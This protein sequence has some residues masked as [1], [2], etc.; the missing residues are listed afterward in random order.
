M[1]NVLQDDCIVIEKYPFGNSLDHLRDALRK[2]EESYD[3]VDDGSSQGAQE[4]VS[5]LLLALMG[6]KS[7]Y[8]L[9]SQF[10]NQNVAYEIS[11]LFR[12]I[13]N[14]DFHYERY[15][16]LVRLVIHKASDAEIWSAVF[17]L[18]TTISRLTP[19]T[20]IAPSFDGTPIT[21]SSASQQGSEQTE[22]LSKA[23]IF[24]EIMKC[25]Y[26]GVGGF[27]SKY[28]EGKVWTQRSKEIYNTMKSR[29]VDGQWIDFP[30]PPVQNAVSE[31]LFRFQDEFLSDARG[32]YYTTKK[33][34]EFTGAEAPRQLD[35]FVKR[36]SETAST[37]HD[38]KDVYIIGEHKQT[39]DHLKPL[40]LQLSRYMR[41][42]FTAQPRR[43]FIHGF[44]LH[45]TTMEPW[46]FDRSGP[47]S[48]GEFDIHEEPE[49]FI[50][51]IT[52]Y[53]MMSDEELGLDTFV[54]R[55]RG[56]LFITIT[57][58]ATGK[59]KRLQLE[60][61][62]IAIQRAI[63]CRGTSCYRTED[64]EN[65]A[66]FSWTS[67]KRPSEADLLRLALQKG[68]E[69]VARL[70]G[71]HRITSIEEMREK[72]TFPT[73]HHFRNTSP[74]ASESFSESFSQSQSLQP[75]SQS[76]GSFRRL[77]IVKTSSNKRKS[78]DSEAKCSKRS[79]S[80][81][82]RSKLH[83]E[84]KVTEALEST[85]TTERKAADN[86]AKL[87]KK[88]TST[89][90][91]SKPLQE[92]NVPQ[93]PKSAHTRKR[94]S[95]D[96]GEKPSKR[97]RSDSQRSNVQQ[98]Y[99]VLQAFKDT[100]DESFDNRVFGC[101]VIWPAGRAIKDFHSIPELLTALRDAIKAHKSLYLRATILHRDI[102]ENNMI[103]TNPKQT[104]GFTGMLIDADL[105]KIIGGGRTGA[106]YQT[107]TMEF[108]A[109]QVLRKVDHTYRHD[110]ESFFY[111]LL[112]I[113]ARRAW[114]REF[115][116]KW[117]DRPKESMLRKWYTGSYKEIAQS[118]EYAMGVNGFEELLEEFPLILECI[119]PLCR[120]IR[121]ILFPY[122]NG[123]F[124]GTPLDPKELYDPI[125]KAFDDAI[126]KERARER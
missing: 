98:G 29:H 94:K 96:N 47:Y 73:P 118:K 110:L 68:V 62:P 35:L 55:N 46:V 51:A 104:K 39:K 123:M 122:Q 101:L 70:L 24:H 43:R 33:T 57:E 120:E 7:A 100:H 71:Y 88:S 27:F 119:M 45:G 85:Q 93:A 3:A 69:G 40:L 109:I 75:L 79:R 10:S 74:N 53:A 59:E 12:R 31:W 112:W 111:V 54:E 30:D 66:K 8:I 80:N 44:F 21:H 25:T 113:C 67:H 106:R 84:H 58:D 87:F 90:Q 114:E 117:A 56:D 50:Q 14:H 18:I 102:S 103:I 108:M 16:A 49:Q 89:S 4:A 99:E 121:G 2:V 64:S 36:R 48:S 60:R 72:L 17:N 19:P 11:T 63:V 37:T 52:G 42:V 34:S 82:Q 76:F 116:C 61:D 92:H 81:S 41:D 20:S 38:W 125:I 13:Q 91:R 6:Q 115:Q 22:K 97:S 105:A 95:D 65:V 78:S 83:R 9:R 15:R 86:E 32:V 28:F 124:T 1:A 23:P 126:A 107:G 5:S 77:S 26:R